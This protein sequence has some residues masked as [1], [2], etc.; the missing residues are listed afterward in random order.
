ML[1]MQVDR[2]LTQLTTANARERSNRKASWATGHITRTLDASVYSG[3]A[4][5]AS[6]CRLWGLPT[7]T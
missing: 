1:R 4:V 5:G 6:K 7:L 2:M 3:G